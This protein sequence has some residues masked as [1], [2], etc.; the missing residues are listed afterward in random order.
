MTIFG[1]IVYSGAGF[2]EDVFH[3]CQFRDLGFC[4]RIAAQLIRH[5]LAWPFGT[6]GKHALE[7]ALGCR[8]VATLLQQDIEFGTVLINC[9]PQQIRLAAQRNKHFVE[10]P[11]GTRLA[12]RSLDAMGEARAEFVAP[13]PDCFIANDHPAL[14]QQ[15]FDIAQA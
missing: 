1:A 14:K 11:G 3:V 8:L 10:M 15:L 2:D 4:S 7:K 9:T 5:D 6:S 13:A 12:T